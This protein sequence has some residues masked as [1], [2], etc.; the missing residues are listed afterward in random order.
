MLYVG[1]RIEGACTKTLFRLVANPQCCESIRSHPLLCSNG[2]SYIEFVECSELA[3]LRSFLYGI[4]RIAEK[5]ACK[6]D[7]WPYR[8]YY[9]CLMLVR[10]GYAACMGC[11]LLLLLLLLLLAA[12][13]PA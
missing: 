1:C 10:E 2:C 11:M 8:V 6:M 9:V 5:N 3:F 12:I 7:A 4:F 13:V